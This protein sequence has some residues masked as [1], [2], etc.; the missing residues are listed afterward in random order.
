MYEKKSNLRHHEISFQNYDGCF[1][2][3]SFIQNHINK[4][5]KDD[6]EGNKQ[7]TFLNIE[8]PATIKSP[9]KNQ[10]QTN[11]NDMKNSEYNITF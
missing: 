11:L 7:T 9:T 5:Q 10:S 3:P 6:G 2:E 1:H 4:D 8:I